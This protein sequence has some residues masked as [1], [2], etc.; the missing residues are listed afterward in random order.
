[1]EEPGQRDE[2]PANTESPDPVSRPIV[3]MVRHWGWIPRNSGSPIARYRPLGR[4]DTLR[5]ST[6]KKAEHIL[7]ITVQ[8]SDNKILLIKIV[9]RADCASL[10]DLPR[11]DERAAGAGSRHKSA[12]DWYPQGAV[13]IFDSSSH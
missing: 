2:K 10:Y 12:D 11:A 1:V 6:T 9:L 8:G 7:N 13:E 5:N 3:G 4:R